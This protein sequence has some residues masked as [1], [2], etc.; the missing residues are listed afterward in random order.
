MSA[1][2][3]YLTRDTA[4]TSARSYGDAAAWIAERTTEG[5]AART[6]DSDEHIAFEA[7]GAPSPASR[8]T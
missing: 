5:K 8:P 6:L 2:E 1:V 4:H 7:L 3:S